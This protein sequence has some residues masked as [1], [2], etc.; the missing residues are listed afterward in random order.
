MKYTE[1]AIANVQNYL[2]YKGHA[3]PTISDDTVHFID[4]TKGN[5]RFVRS[6]KIDTILEEMRTLKRVPLEAYTDKA[7][8]TAGSM[9]FGINIYQVMEIGERLAYREDIPLNLRGKF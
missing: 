2:L 1:V 9:R 6:V 7:A 5:L 8:F 3:R 4:Q